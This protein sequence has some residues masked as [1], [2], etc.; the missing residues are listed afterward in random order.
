MKKKSVILAL[1]LFVSLSCLAQKKGNLFLL[2]NDAS[3]IDSTF[4]KSDSVEIN[5][6]SLK[7]TPDTVKYQFQRD[8]KGN[9]KKKISVKTTK[10]KFIDL[11][12]RNTNNNNPRILV[13]KIDTSNTMTFKEI[14]HAK[15]LKE[16]RKLISTY[17]R[18]YLIHEEEKYGNFYVAKRVSMKSSRINM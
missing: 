1:L 9:L 5:Y 11:E 13:N 16:L 15:S 2:V 6:Y 10:S 18:I 8:E 17:E 7:L 4:S 12:Y 14:F 3:K